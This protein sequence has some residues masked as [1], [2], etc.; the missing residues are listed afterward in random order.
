[1]GID[2]LDRVKKTKVLLESTCPFDSSQSSFNNVLDRKTICY[3]CLALDC[4]NLGN[5]A[6]KIPLEIG[7]RVLAF[8]AGTAKN[9]S[10]PKVEDGVEN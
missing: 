9:V 2:L 5:T 6:H 8:Q 7:A 3:C 1:M 4:K 10:L